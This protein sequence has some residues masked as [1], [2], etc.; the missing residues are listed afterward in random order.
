MELEEEKIE[1]R[2]SIGKLPDR[3]KTIIALKYGAELSN[4]EIAEI[5]GISTTNT[6]VILYRCLKK[7]KSD[8]EEYYEK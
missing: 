8:M 4:G 5:M 2:K 7:I 1:L 6:G 3:E